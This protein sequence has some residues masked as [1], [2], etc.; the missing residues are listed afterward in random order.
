MK[1][2]WFNRSMRYLFRG[3]FR[4][5]ATYLRGIVQGHRALK[6]YRRTQDIRT[7]IKKV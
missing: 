4:N 2:Y 5:F 7:L 1:I 6:E 3:R